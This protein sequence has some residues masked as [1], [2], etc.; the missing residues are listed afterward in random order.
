MRNPSF[1]V[2]ELSVRHH[3]IQQL[4][5]LASCDGPTTTCILTSQKAFS[6]AGTS[7]KPD[8]DFYSA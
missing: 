6:A 3:E 1:F 7:L 8:L 2:E 5:A 4:I